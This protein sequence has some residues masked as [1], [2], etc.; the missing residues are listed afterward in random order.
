MSL[1]TQ[2]VY[3]MQSKT[4]SDM[5]NNVFIR[6]FKNFIYS[7]VYASAAVFFVLLPFF[8]GESRFIFI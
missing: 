3:V 4:L 1:F 5:T 6:Y 7:S 8:F 2:H